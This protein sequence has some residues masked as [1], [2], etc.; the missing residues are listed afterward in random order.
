MLLNSFEAEKVNNLLASF[1]V[2]SMLSTE[3]ITLLLLLQLYNNVKQNR[4]AITPACLNAIK[5]L[6]GV[7]KLRLYF[8]LGFLFNSSNQFF[9]KKFW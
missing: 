2:S 4:P 3:A 9:S 1:S 6:F 5:R 7:D 8:S